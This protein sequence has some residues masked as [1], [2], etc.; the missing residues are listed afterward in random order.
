[1]NVFSPHAQNLKITEN[2]FF[3][4]NPVNLGKC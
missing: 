1:M 2:M 4:K 3:I